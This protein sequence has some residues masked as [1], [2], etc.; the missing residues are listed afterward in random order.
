MTDAAAS[1]DAPYT[2]RHWPLWRDT[3]SNVLVKR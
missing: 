2:S 3:I 1:V